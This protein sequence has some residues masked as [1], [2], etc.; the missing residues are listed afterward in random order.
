MNRRNFLALLGGGVVVAAG[1]TLGVVASRFPDEAVEPW[2]SAGVQYKE[3]RLRA[4]SFAILAPNPH[5]RQPWLVDLSKDNQITLTVDTNKLLPHTDPFSRQ[6]TIGLGCFLEVLRMALAE[7]GYRADMNIF[8]EGSDVA[9]LDQRPVAVIDLVKDANIKPDPLF[10]HI[11]NRRSLKDPFDV[12]KPVSDDIIKRVQA[13]AIYGTI[14]ASNDSSSVDKMRQITNDALV[15]EIVTPRT[16]KESVD[17]FR[18][19]KK[20]VNDN[21]DGIDFTGPFFETAYFVG[22]F[23]REGALD[24]ASTMF[25]EGLKASAEQA[26][27]G[28]A[29]LWLVSEKNDREHQ[30]K[31]GGDWVRVNLATTR[32]GVGLHPMSQSLQEYPEMKEIYDE[33]QTLL[34]PDG[35]AVQMLGRLGYAAPIGPSPR[36]PIE[37]KVVS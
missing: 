3:P 17:L 32:E 18:I 10:A 12:N 22:G 4:L 30:I 28:M 31:T 26:N 8:P 5:N 24:T 16:Y 21:P 33:V 7:E 23:N 35:G 14:G 27:T 20:E 25:K 37:A 1:S 9:E 2:K 29:H 15:V 11:P 6:I 34:A 19:G 36:W 13:A